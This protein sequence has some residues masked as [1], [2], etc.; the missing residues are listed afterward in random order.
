MKKY[1]FRFYGS[2][3]EFRRQY[4]SC[5][6]DAGG[7]FLLDSFRIEERGGEIRFLV[8]SCYS[9]GYWYLPEMTWDGQTLLFSG[10]IRLIDAYHP[11]K[12]F[13]RF[14]AVVGDVCTLVLLFPVA[15]PVWLFCRL[16]LGKREEKEPSPEADLSLLMEGKLHCT[17]AD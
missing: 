1:T 7:Q 11:E 13:R 8:R 10:G 4:R 5:P 2:E 15:A 3:E 6:R 16:F 17:P 9:G 12:G 14:W